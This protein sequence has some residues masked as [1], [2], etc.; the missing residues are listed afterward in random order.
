MVCPRCSWGNCTSGSSE[1][2]APAAPEDAQRHVDPCPEGHVASLPVPLV[3][4]HPHGLA[5]P[6]F[7]GHDIQGDRQDGS[8]PLEEHRQTTDR[9]IPPYPDERGNHSLSP[10]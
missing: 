4:H 5:A 3:L 8:L 10:E 2:S 6:E 7:R 9:V 1:S